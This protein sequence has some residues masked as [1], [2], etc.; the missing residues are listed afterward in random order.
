MR[1]PQAYALLA[2][3]RMFDSLQG[4]ALFDEIDMAVGY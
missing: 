2:T 4:S 3:R 1:R